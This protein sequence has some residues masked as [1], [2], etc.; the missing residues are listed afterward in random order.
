MTHGQLRHPTSRRTAPWIS[1][2]TVAVSLALFGSIAVSAQHQDSRDDSTHQHH[3]PT[4]G[5]DGSPAGKAYSEFNHHLA[6][7]CV[8]FIGVS[9]LRDGV[10]MT[11]LSWTRFLLP[12]AM[13]AAG[14]YLIVWS[15]HDAWPIGS[16]SVVETFFGGDVE[17]LQHK[18]YALLLLAVGAIEWVI[19][20]GRVRRRLWT[21][22][23]PAFAIVGGAFLFLHSHGTHP[24]AHKIAMH[25]TAMGVAA[26]LAGCCRAVSQYARAP[27]PM[28]DP[29]PGAR[30]GWLIAWASLVLVIGVQLLTYSE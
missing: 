8:P 14:A 21:I 24:A 29:R 10:G 18:L 3:S 15:D 5:W 11:V 2:V 23:L 28:T 16:R 7:V 9:E 26:V 4:D 25:H 30:S 22:F 17:T 1:S 12:S 19:R 13:L 27:F 6:G 20:S